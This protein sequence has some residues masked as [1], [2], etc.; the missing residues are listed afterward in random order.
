[1]L[2]E[3][4]LGLPVWELLERR[5]DG[6]D[7]RA[8]DHAVERAA[9]VGLGAGHGAEHPHVDRTPGI[10]RRGREQAG[11]DAVVGV[12][13]PRLPRVDDRSRRILR[14][15]QLEGGRVERRDRGEL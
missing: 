2:G 10:R 15:T 5:G 12:R 1:V 14:P 6:I 11:R 8:R 9:G 3:V 4:A 13:R 7:P